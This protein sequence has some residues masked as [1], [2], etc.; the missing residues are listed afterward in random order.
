MGNR[1]FIKKKKKDPK[2]VREGAGV[3]T[4]AERAERGGAG[5]RRQPRWGRGGGT[6]AVR[7]LRSGAERERGGRRSPAQPRGAAAER[8]DPPQPS[9]LLTP[10][11]PPDPAEVSGAGMRG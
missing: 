3:R 6:C 11:T 1:V 7:A 5:R 9:P 8:G 2:V 4:G 10:A